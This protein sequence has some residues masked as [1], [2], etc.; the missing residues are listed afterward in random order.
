MG[1]MLPNLA[2]FDIDHNSISGS[3]PA[4]ISNATNLVHLIMAGNK[5]EGQIPSLRLLQKLQTLALFDNQLGI[6]DPATDL[7]FVSSL[8]NSTMLTRFVLGNNKL[9]GEFPTIFCDFPML[10]HLVAGQN[11][12]TGEIPPCIGNLT[13]LIEFD[14]RENNISGTIPDSIVRLHDL[15]NLFLDDNL[16]S[17]YIPSSIGNLTQ[18]TYFVA[19]G[20]NLEGHIPSTLG[21]CEN[22]LH[23]DLSSNNLSGEI[24]AELLRLSIL[25]FVLDLSSN[26][27]TGPLSDEVGGLVS[28]QQ[29]FVSDN[30]LSGEIPSSLSACV[31]LEVLSM[32]GNFFQGHIPKELSNTSLRSLQILDL[33]R[34]N[35]SGSIPESLLG[36]PLT[37]LNLSYNNLQGEVPTSGVFSNATGF[38]VFGNAKLCGGPPELKLHHCRDSHK[39]HYK[40]ALLVGI[41]VFIVLVAVV[42]LY[43]IFQKKGAEKPTD[44]EKA[45]T[46]LSLYTIFHRRRTKETPGLSDLEKALT[47]LTY[48]MLHRATDGFSSENLIGSGAS[49]VVYK[50]TLEN[51]K[52]VLAIKIFNLEHRAASK[53]FIAE[54]KALRSIRHRNL[55]TVVTAC[56]SLDYKGNDFK[57]IVYEYMAKGSLDDWLH[58]AEGIRGGNSDNAPRNLN[59]CQRFEIAVDVA[60]ALEYLHH[61]CGSSVI[62][63]DLKPSN[64]LLDEDMVAHV[65]DFGLAKFLSQG[66]VSANQSSSMGIRGTVG[67]VPPE[68]GMGNEVSMCGDVYSFGIL[69]LEM[70]TGKRPTDDVFKEGR[71]LRDFVN[72]AIS[73]QDIRIVDD[74]LLQ[75]M[76]AEDSNSQIVFEVVTS[77]LETALAC[78]AELPQERPDMSDI[79]E[80][81]SSIQ[82]KLQGHHIER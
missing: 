76:A 46:D 53:S 77:V 20:N 12:I 14:V 26:S 74:A 36:L 60:F 5:L 37:L 63:C 16:L 8:A 49:G 40:M 23:L 58:P 80:K 51:V 1:N 15:E 29:L 33:S 18:L 69:L 52:T 71:S 2:Y 13:K 17:G 10:S 65:G 34:N 61:T 30:L 81:L 54:C 25:S 78:S 31:E 19:Y 3:I 39:N 82:T 22:L 55:V 75:D 67:Y 4:S 6:G 47:S 64:V 73:E 35:L 48:Q 32:Q 27:L 28:L 62:H 24:P 43:I 44:V 42:S 79:V 72:V 21:N 59:L 66:I 11:H 56:S 7:D 50:G 45:S 38:S 41:P 9:S 68:Y 70:F 57:A